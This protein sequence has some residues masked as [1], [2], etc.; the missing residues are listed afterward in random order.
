M[1]LVKIIYVSDLINND[2]EEITNN[3]DR[4]ERTNNKEETNDTKKIIF[5]GTTTKYQMK[6]VNTNKEKKEKKKKVE[7]NTWGLNEEELSFDI[8]LNILKNTS[9]NSIINDSKLTNFI[10]SHIKTKISSY[11]HQDLLKNIF[12][13]SDF[14]TFDHIIELLNECNMK[15]HY[16]ACETYLL[17]EFVREMKQ[18]SLD[19]IN[20]DIGHNKGNLVIACLECNLK[21]R[22][23]NKDAFF[24][25]KNLTISRE[26][27]A[28]NQ[29]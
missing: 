10:I 18:W 6:K 15:C 3:N 29:V 11:K 28:N 5:T 27:I 9:N 19:R 2:R 14:V 26:G 20:N 25:T 21:R 24:M 8:Q 12:L 23:T 4:E 16:C 7:T 22:R 1:D 13:E 17:Y